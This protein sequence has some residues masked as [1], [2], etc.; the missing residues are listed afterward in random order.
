MCCGAEISLASRLPWA[1]STSLAE[2]LLWQR[3]FLGR[4]RRDGTDVP[5][6][7][8]MRSKRLRA[9]R[10]QQV[11]SSQVGG[12]LLPGDG[13]D[14]VRRKRPQVVLSGG[15]GRAGEEIFWYLGGQSLVISGTQSNRGR[16]ADYT[17][18]GRFVAKAVAQKYQLEMYFECS[19]RKAGL[20]RLLKIINLK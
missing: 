14:A 8:I 11:V 5:R 9:H 10:G 16:Y 7:L 2:I 18:S 3:Y 13:V 1:S 17:V 4:E 6:L 12:Q 20:G 19:S 15:G